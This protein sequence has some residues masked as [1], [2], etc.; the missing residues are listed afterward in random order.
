MPPG[1]T[2][3]ASGKK[4]LLTVAVDDNMA[5]P[6]CVVLSSMKRHAASPF[7][8]VVGHLQGSLTDENLRLI[9]EVAET[10]GIPVVFRELEPDALFISQGH[11]SP[12]TFTKFLLS[13]AIPDSHLWV[14]ADTI[15]H[16]GWDQLFDLVRSAPA[17]AELVVAQRG[18]RGNKSVTRT[19]DPSLLAFNAGVLG[20]PNAPRRPWRD[21]LAVLDSFAT[22]EQYLLNH[23]YS[24]ATFAVP[25]SYN[26]LTYRVDRVP[27][28]EI[29]FI[30]HFA[31][32][33][34]PWHL[35]RSLSHLCEEYGCPWALWFL[36]ERYL[37]ENMTNSSLRGRLR[38][39]QKKALESSRFR[40]GRD[41]SG[42]NL[43]TTLR[44][45]GPFKV[46]L[47]RLLRGLSSK[48]PRGTHPLHPKRLT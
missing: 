14:D 36:E 34:K 30:L 28:G 37:F 9:K 38:R 45:M 33:H 7:S 12:T 6:L 10:L 17:T 23:L 2:R 43:V 18:Y 8:L 48:V 16:S 29:P 26:T 20:W 21:A 46:P 19:D 13:D 4:N 47:T 27:P 42:L 5:F 39:A 44:L 41:F 32:A 22:Q 24:G 1:K 35:H 40:P 15:V 11:I 31:G 25:E 3:R